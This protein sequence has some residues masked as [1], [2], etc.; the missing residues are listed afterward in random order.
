MPFLPP[1]QQRQSTEGSFG[2]L[3]ALEKKHQLKQRRQRMHETNDLKKDE[4]NCKNTLI[5]CALA[6][7]HKG[8]N[9]VNTGALLINHNCSNIRKIQA[10]M[11]LFTVLA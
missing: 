8:Q 11:A 4:H 3:L 10:T 6:L 2:L 1:N 5:T 7:R 9:A